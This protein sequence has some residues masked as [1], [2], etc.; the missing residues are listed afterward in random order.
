MTSPDSR[1][2]LG[3]PTKIRFPLPA[4]ATIDGAPE[5]LYLEAE[6]YWG[7]EK[8]HTLRQTIEHIYAPEL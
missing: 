3:R 8:Q 4:R 2:P 5:T 6:L 7:G 1:P